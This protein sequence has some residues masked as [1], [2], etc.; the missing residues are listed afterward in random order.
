MA[1][2]D[3]TEALLKPAVSQRSPQ[4]M[5]ANSKREFGMPNVEWI[6]LKSQNW[7]M[8]YGR[9]CRHHHSETGCYCYCYLG[10]ALLHI[11]SMSGKQ[12]RYGYT[13]VRFCKTSRIVEWEEFRTANKDSTHS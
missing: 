3:D 11:A 1:I 4:P 5:K 12:R 6:N 10:R 7:T 9:N 13:Y 8:S 2:S